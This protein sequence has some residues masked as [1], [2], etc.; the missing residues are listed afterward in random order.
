VPSI[1][2]LKVKYAQFYSANRTSNPL[3]RIA[4]SKS[5]E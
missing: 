4:E 2:A 3:L 5:S 1:L